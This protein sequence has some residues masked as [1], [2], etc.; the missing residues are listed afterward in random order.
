VALD[1]MDVLPWDDRVLIFIMLP[2]FHCCAEAADRF[3]VIKSRWFWSQAIPNWL[4]VKI[5]RSHRNKTGAFLFKIRS[6]RERA[7]RH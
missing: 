2:A 7:S 4:Y 1:G 3:E 5:I 6:E